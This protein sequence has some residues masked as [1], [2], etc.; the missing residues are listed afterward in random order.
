MLRPLLTL[1]YVGFNHFFIAR[2]LSRSSEPRSFSPIHH[3]IVVCPYSG[4]TRMFDLRSLVVEW[5]LVYSAPFV[6]PF[7]LA[8]HPL[9][10]SFS[11]LPN[12]IPVRT[13]FHRSRDGRPL[14]DFA[15]GPCLLP[16]SSSSSLSLPPA[17][18]SPSFLDVAFDPRSPTL[19]L[20]SVGWSYDR[21]I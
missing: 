11:H 17:S 19:R 9:W 18:T 5:S 13:T 20:I 8:C 15:G 10:P 3:L 21:L 2:P 7:P 12:F 14:F 16:R 4:G 1:I 6:S